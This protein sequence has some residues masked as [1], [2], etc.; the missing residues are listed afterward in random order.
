MKY[1]KAQSPTSPA[2]IPRE[3]AE[4]LVIR[5]SN[6]PWKVAV[7]AFGGTSIVPDRKED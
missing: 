6:S 5:E 3:R 7:I 1:S 4:D 2:G